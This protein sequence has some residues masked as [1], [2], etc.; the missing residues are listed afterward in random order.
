[1]GHCSGCC[2]PPNPR[3]TM[4]SMGST[5]QMRGVLGRF[6][7]DFWRYSSRMDDETRAVAFQRVRMMTR[8]S[9]VCFTE[10]L[11]RNQCW[12]Y[13]Q[14]SIVKMGGQVWKSSQGRQTTKA[15]EKWQRWQIWLDFDVKQRKQTKGLFCVC[16]SAWFLS[17]TVFCVCFVFAVVCLLVC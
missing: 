4:S 12:Q 3:C 10:R 17:C 5:W 11:E 13:L 8:Q 9:P 1:M 6:G 16:L 14:K 2:E 15:G 7:Q